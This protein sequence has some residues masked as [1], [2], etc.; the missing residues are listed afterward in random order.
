MFDNFKNEIMNFIDKIVNLI[1][2][3]RQFFS[4]DSLLISMIILYYLIDFIY[5]YIYVC[6]CVCSTPTCKQNARTFTQT[7][8]VSTLTT[9]K[10]QDK[11]IN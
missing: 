4:S 2:I 1:Y 11:Q 9:T 6:V 8:L 7:R 5:I 3:E 10:K